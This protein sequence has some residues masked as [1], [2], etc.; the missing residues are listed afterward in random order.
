M[1]AA[2]V[3]RAGGWSP[4]DHPDA[5]AHSS[6][7]DD[8]PRLE[9][10]LMLIHGLADDNVVVAHTLRLSSALQRAAQC[11][12]AVRHHPR[13][14]DHRWCSGIAVVWLGTP[15]RLTRLLSV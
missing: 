6:L 8:A 2:R 12:P 10:P 15:T 5:H 3:A 1:A 13:R 9:R 11:A 7:I 14:V 4:D